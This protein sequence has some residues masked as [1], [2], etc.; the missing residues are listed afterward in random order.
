MQTPQPLVAVRDHG[1]GVCQQTQ[2]SL[3]PTPHPEGHR[4]GCARAAGHICG[5]NAE[6]SRSVSAHC[7]LCRTVMPLHACSVCHTL[8][9]GNP[10]ACSSQ[11]VELAACMQDALPSPA[12]ATD[13]G[14]HAGAKGATSPLF[15][16]T[17]SLAACFSRDQG[18]SSTNLAMR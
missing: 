3:Q 10:A 14:Q 18:S 12:T 13:N 11:G 7:T 6:E 16:M 15:L 4:Q 1:H 9:K 5:G 2:H 8:L 17:D